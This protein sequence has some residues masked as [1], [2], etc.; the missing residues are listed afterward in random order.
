MR[1][2]KRRR[3]L[4]DGVDGSA[5]ATLMVST[6]ACTLLLPCCCRLPNV[7]ARHLPCGPQDH[8]KVGAF[9]CHGIDPAAGTEEGEVDKSNQDCACI[10][11]PVRGDRG[12]A[13]FSV[14]DGHGAKGAE[15]SMRVLQSIHHELNSR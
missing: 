5:L 2:F 4:T 8:S 6:P 11:Y 13:L 14:F 10:V 1:S 7:R 12:A 9:S 15:V 3:N